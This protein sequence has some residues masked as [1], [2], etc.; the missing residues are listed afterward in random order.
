M[1]DQAPTLNVFTEKALAKELGVVPETVRK[2]RQ[3]GTGP[4]YARLGGKISGPIIYRAEDVQAWI[5]DH[6]HQPAPVEASQ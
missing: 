1:S 5:A 3:W 2:W 6:I 4:A